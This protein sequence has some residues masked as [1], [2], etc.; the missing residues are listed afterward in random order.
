MGLA[1]GLLRMVERLQKRHGKRT[2]A[3]M[4]LSDEQ[5]PAIGL[6]VVVSQKMPLLSS[7]NRYMH[8][9][10]ESYW[11]IS[12]SFT[13]FASVTIWEPPLGL[14][15]TSGPFSASKASF[16]QVAVPNCANLF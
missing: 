2:D 9:R 16:N 4:S 15:S 5:V 7:M 8:A 14:T 13:L 12:A 11:L 6:L 3:Q 1:M 10:Y